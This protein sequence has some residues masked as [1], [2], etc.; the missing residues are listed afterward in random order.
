M[1]I[2]GIETSCD[3]TAAAVVELKNNRFRVLSSAV[4]SQVDLHKL[5][6]G[7]VPEVAARE[8]VT[9]IMPTIKLALNRATIQMSKSKFQINSKAQNSK[10]N[11]LDAIAV[12]AGP[13]L[14]PALLVGVDTANALSL[15][16]GI[17]AIPVQHITGHI[18]ANFVGKSEIRKPPPW[19]EKSKR[20]HNDLRSDKNV[21]DVRR[22]K[23]PLLALVV[24]GG[25]SEFILMK[26]YL[27]FTAK[28]P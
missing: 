18:Y 14:L 4:A 12:T 7:V 22:I 6:G 9:T 27:Q 2:L 21:I 19:A 1:K 15:A 20:Y 17:P 5:T 25:H 16:T 24:S 3:E 23:F 28:K 13:G 10:L 26:N 8:H 11:S